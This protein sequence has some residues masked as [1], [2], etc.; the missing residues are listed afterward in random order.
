MENTATGRVLMAYMSSSSF[1]S[2]LS[3]RT[4]EEKEQL[5]SAEFKAMLKGIRAAGYSMVDVV[6]QNTKSYALP[7]F[8]ADN[9]VIA[10][11]GILYHNDADSPEYR[12]QILKAGKTAANEISRR[13]AFE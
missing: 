7:V 10:A 12:A 3:L 8:D 6:S 5:T 13:L 9:K 4:P 2:A 11:L 1:N